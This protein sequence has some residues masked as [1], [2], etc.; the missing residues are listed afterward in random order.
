MD[1][2]PPFCTKIKCF[3][4]QPALVYKTTQCY[5]VEEF[6][7]KH[8]K[9]LWETEVGHLQSTDLA[10]TVNSCHLWVHNL[11]FSGIHVKQQ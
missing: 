6:T 2:I 8:R 1:E 11:F 9:S 7:L 4:E 5:C 3:S 10:H